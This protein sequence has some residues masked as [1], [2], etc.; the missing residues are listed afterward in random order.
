MT[1]K[2]KDQLKNFIQ[3]NA[4]YIRPVSEIQELIQSDHRLYW[5]EE[6]P[7]FNFY[8]ELETNCDPLVQKHQQLQTNIRTITRPNSLEEFKTQFNADTKA[9]ANNK[10]EQRID[11][12][13]KQQ[14]QLR[15]QFEIHFTNYFQ[16]F[17]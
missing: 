15:K 2:N 12:L 14:E 7:N 5:I 17:L 10:A 1:N 4:G 8:Q 11:E 3:N 13:Q 16:Q 9:E 6:Q